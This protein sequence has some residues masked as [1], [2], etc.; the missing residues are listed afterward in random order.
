M[1]VESVA[2]HAFR[3]S[4]KSSNQH[5]PPTFASRIEVNESRSVSSSREHLSY[6][7]NACLFREQRYKLVPRYHPCVPSI[8]ELPA[9]LPLRTRRARRKPKR[10]RGYLELR[11]T[12]NVT[13][14][15]PA[16][17]R[18]RTHI[19]VQ[20]N[21]AARFRARCMCIAAPR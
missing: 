10:K 7:F 19:A 4:F 1:Y 21:D 14:K 8:F 6:V 9:E 17:A 16:C 3:Y 2:A 12:R 15:V 18:A 5:T 13:Y 20:H 11:N